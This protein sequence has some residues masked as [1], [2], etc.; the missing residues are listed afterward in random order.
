MLLN[1]VP[2]FSQTQGEIA[3][4]QDVI[5]SFS[6]LIGKQLT[7]TGQ[8]EEF[9][10]ANGEKSD[11]S[12]ASY[13]FV[14]TFVYGDA[15]WIRVNCSNYQVGVTSDPTKHVVKEMTFIYNGDRWYSL[16]LGIIENGNKITV[17]NCKIEKSF[18]AWLGAGDPSLGSGMSIF[19]PL[20]EIYH[21]KTFENLIANPKLD[22]KYKLEIKP[23]I[24]ASNIKISFEDQCSASELSLTKAT[25]NFMPDKL[26][27]RLNICGPEVTPVSFEYIF[28]CENNFNLN[29]AKFNYPSS[30]E[31]QMTVS[32]NLRNSSKVTIK[33][34]EVSVPNEKR[35][36]QFEPGWLI[37]D[38]HLGITYVTGQSPEEMLRSVRSILEK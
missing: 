33:K 2:C 31:R 35:E 18:P 32:G 7:I 36:V 14:T 8:Y 3:V 4:L 16:D 6:P 29:E 10:A 28:K 11:Q 37:Q 23:D 13:E 25:F 1:M 27:K 30:V 22:F 26:I 9:A 20:L 15:S 17:K 12:S 34:I 24:S 21:K 38:E 5:A 19:L